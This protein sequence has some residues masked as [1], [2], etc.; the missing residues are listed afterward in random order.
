MANYGRNF[1][2]RIPPEGNERP[3]RFVSPSTGN[4]LPIGVPVQADVSEAVDTLGRQPIELVTGAAPTPKGNAGILVYEYAPAAFAG[5]DPFL[6]TYSDKDT[7]PLG[8]SVQVVH[9]PGIKVVLTN[10]L[11]TAV[12]VDFTGVYGTQRIIVAGI[13]ATPTVIV[14]DYLT[15]GTGNDT[16]G[17][18]AETGSAANAWLVVTHVDT[19]RHEVE[20]ELVF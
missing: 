6:V 5:D 18:W 11:D 13:G 4:H 17:Y 19:V 12:G 3:G 20:A 16:A 8:A 10:T 1:A 9:G 7:A 14:G 2:F 15:P